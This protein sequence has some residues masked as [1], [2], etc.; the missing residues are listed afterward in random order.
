MAK[1]KAKPWQLVNRYKDPLWRR[2]LSLRYKQNNPRA[3]RHEAYRDMEI[4]G[5]DNFEEFRDFVYSEIGAYPGTDYKLS[6]LDHN[7]GYVTGNLQWA[8]DNVEVSRGGSRC[9][10]ITYKRRTM[11]VS[12]WG[13]Q[14]GID[15]AVILA[16]L[17]YG[18]PVNLALTVEPHY[19]N[20]LERIVNDKKIKTKP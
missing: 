8:A 14:V 10:F 19:G 3:P 18:W 9:K 20:K 15:P 7:Q 16:R 11:M 17:K 13:R 2:W 6:R 5:I 12:D 4:T 1:K